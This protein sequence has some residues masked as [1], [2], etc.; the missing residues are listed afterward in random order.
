MSRDVIEIYETLGH[1]FSDPALL[2]QAFTLGFGNYLIG[3]ER[4]EFLGDRVLGLIVAEMLFKSFPSESEGDLARRHSD[5]VKTDTLAKIAGSLDFGQY[6]IIPKNEDSSV[7]R[8]SKTI[9][10]DVC[11][12]VIAALYLDGGLSA[13]ERFVLKYWIPLMNEFQVPPVDAKTKLQELVQSKG[14]PL[15]EYS[16]LNVS[17]P[18][19]DPVFV[20]QV[21]IKGYPPV[22]AKGKSKRT[23]SQEAA[24]AM[25]K[26]IEKK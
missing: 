9:L 8:N 2:K 22:S 19:H 6:I 13:A 18:D 23:G 21:Q 7:D 26:V 17:G 12:A 16:V 20:I 11:E 14:L 5:L 24:A 15:P 1:S 4:F 10:A 3:Y 25:L